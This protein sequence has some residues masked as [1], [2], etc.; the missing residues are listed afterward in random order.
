M[1]LKYTTVCV[2]GDG[3][4]YDLGQLEF[5]P[6]SPFKDGSIRDKKFMVINAFTCTLE[7]VTRLKKKKRK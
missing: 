5:P 4:V 2:C 6:Q 7:E 1:G 3:A